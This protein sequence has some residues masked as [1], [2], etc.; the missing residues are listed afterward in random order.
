M[1]DSA[2]NNDSDCTD[3]ASA[4][5]VISTREL[6]SSEVRSRWIDTLD[7]TYCELDVDWPDISD[8]FGAEL[9]VRPFVDVTVSV[10]RADPHTVIRTPN[11]ISSD[12]NDDYLL[13][14]I[15]SG[16]AVIGQHSRSAKLES[17]AFGILDSSAPFIVDAQ[18]EFE[19]IVVRAPRA[20]F[21]PHLP[22]EAVAEITGEGFSGR[23]GISR[24]VS[25][26]FV[27]MATDDSLL[28]PNSSASVAACAMDL[29]VSAISERTTPFN[30]TKRVHNKDFRVIQQAMQRHMTD[31]DYSIS[32]LAAELGMSVRYIHKLFSATGTTPRTRLNQQRL[33]RA[34]KLL[35]STDATISTISVR[36]GF[37]DVSHF[38]RAFRRRF[39][40]S[41]LH[42]RMQQLGTSTSSDNR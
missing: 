16:T 4:K 17:G 31:P 40:T 22:L 32:D 33:E 13:C 7:S 36:V 25:R 27:D 9:S 37:R 24:Y 34:R 3:K 28:S 14:L 12:P 29:L 41:P 23:S 30:T 26:L 38:S 42:F 21:A 18:T 35:L 20:V 5:V 2:Q 39:G 19:Q 1:P 11:M 15:T 10:V 6:E 8:S